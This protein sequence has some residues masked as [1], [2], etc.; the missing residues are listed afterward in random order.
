MILRLL[1]PQGVA[2]LAISVALAILL[3]VQGVQTRRW[4]A[5]SASFEQRYREEQSAF[6]TTVSNARA[7][8][9]AA[10]V[11]DRENAARVAGEQL[12]INE[13]T[14]NDFEARLAAARAAAANLSSGRLH[15]SAQATADPGA[16]RNAPV[17][18][19]SDAAAG[20]AQTTG[21]DR[22]PQ[23]DALIA[24]EQAIQLDE[25]IN[26]VRAQHDVRMR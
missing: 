1:G 22:L 14:R 10:R 3:I 26:W 20:V 24:T 6:A 4:K 25:L 8:A 16:G 2:G 13:R 12:A 9:E 11:A 15:N 7:A 23:S 21:Q 5:R 17:S 18:Q 19:L